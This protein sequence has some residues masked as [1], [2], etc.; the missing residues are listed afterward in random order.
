VIAIALVIFIEGAE[1]FSLDRAFS[2]GTTD[3][4]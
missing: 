4:S 2:A 1:A 3:L